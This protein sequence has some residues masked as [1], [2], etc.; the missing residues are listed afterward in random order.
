MRTF[1][2]SLVTSVALFMIIGCSATEALPTPTVTKVTDGEVNIIMNNYNFVPERLAFSTNEKVKFVIAYSFIY[3]PRP[4]T[5]AAKQKKIDGS[6]IQRHDIEFLLKEA[7]K[8]LILNDKNQSIIHIFNHNYIVDG[9][10]FAEEPINVY[11]DSLTHEMTF[12]TAP[13]N[14]LRNIYHVFYNCLK[15]TKMPGIY[16]K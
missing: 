8:Q 10:I 12:I 16:F 5:P 6:K 13:K 15:R 14:N 7:K 9:K 4:G 2:M 11:A 1:S 3:S